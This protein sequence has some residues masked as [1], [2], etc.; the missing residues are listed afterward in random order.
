MNTDCVDPP[1]VTKASALAR[2]VCFVIAILLG[3]ISVFMTLLM[4]LADMNI[5]FGSSPQLGMFLAGWACIG[6][7][8]VATYRLLRRPSFE[9]LWYLVPP[10]I[11]MTIVQWLGT[12]PENQHLMH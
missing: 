9:S 3:L 6:S 4:L 2:L 1:A 8:L 12:F 10:V 11:C 7:A 5:H